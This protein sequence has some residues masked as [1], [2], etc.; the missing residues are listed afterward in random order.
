MVKVFGVKVGSNL[1]WIGEKRLF[2]V[3]WYE[4]LCTSP[5]LTVCLDEEEI[6]ER[7]ITKKKIK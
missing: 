3:P 5:I 2:F 7:K 6:C 4:P 1:T